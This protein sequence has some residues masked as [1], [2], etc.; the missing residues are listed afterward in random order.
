MT[1]CAN[2]PAF[3]VF[4][5]VMSLLYYS[6]KSKGFALLWA[7]HFQNLSAINLKL[8]SFRYEVWRHF[9]KQK[10]KSYDN[11]VKQSIFEVSALFN[12]Y[13]LYARI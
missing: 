13:R 2:F 8:L 6:L 11:T 4:I 3:F 1:L 5:N 7:E 10:L 9:Y 12:F